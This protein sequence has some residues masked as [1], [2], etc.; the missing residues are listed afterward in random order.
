MRLVL[1]LA[2]YAALSCNAW[3]AGPREIVNSNQISLVAGQAKAFVFDEPI[4]RV[5]LIHK[6]IVEAVPQN[7]RQISIVGLKAGITQMFVSTPTGQRIYSAEIVVSPEQ[8]RLVKIYGTGKNEDLNAGYVAVYC[9]EFGCGRPDKD[10]PQP[11][12]ITVERIRRF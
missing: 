9:D 3:A 4:G 5:D 11:T 12:A 10:L 2:A 8:G 1:L 6:D 7:D